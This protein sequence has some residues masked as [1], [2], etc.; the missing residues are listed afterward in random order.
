MYDTMQRHGLDSGQPQ[1]EAGILPVVAV[2]LTKLGLLCGK[3]GLRTCHACVG[4]T[5]L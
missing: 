2:I 1:E 3:H 4:D 5:L